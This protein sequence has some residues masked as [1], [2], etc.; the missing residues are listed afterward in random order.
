MTKMTTA[1]VMGAVMGTTTEAVTGVAGELAKWIAAVVMSTTAKMAGAMAST[2][3]A[4][5][6]AMMERAKELTFGL[7]KSPK[8]SVVKQV[9]SLAES[10]KVAELSRLESSK[11]ELLQPTS[12]VESSRAAL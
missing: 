1:A 9:R 12:S 10:R 3:A 5:S 2:K 6:A 4:M 7:T 8:A 11:A